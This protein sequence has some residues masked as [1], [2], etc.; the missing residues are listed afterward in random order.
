MR[1]IHRRAVIKLT[2]GA[3]A[4]AA[5]GERR[6]APAAQAPSAELVLIGGTI[7]TMDDSSP[8]A[9]A[10]AVRGGRIQAV[11]SD[12]QIKTYISPSTK[13]I[14]LAGK[15]VTP[16]LID[17]HSHAIG[18]GQMQLKYVQLRPPTVTSFDTLNSELAKAAR[19]KPAG[20]WIVGRGFTE[21]REGRFPRRWELDEAAPGHPVLIIHW[22]GQFG[23]A[24]TLALRKAN[25][26][27]A[28][29]KDPYGG[30]YLRDRLTGLPDGVLIH[31]PAIYS[32][33]QPKLDLN[34]RIDCAAWG[35]EQFARQGVTCIHDNF[36]HPQYAMAYVRLE[37]SGRLPCRVR[38]YPYAKNLEACRLLVER[39]R[40]YRGPQ[41]R[42]QGVKLAVD[43]YALM[44]DVP[45]RHRHMAVPMHPQPL[46]N[47]IVAIIHNADLQADVHAVGDKGV[48]WTLDAFAKAAGSTAECR[49]RRHRIEHFL[50]RNVDSIRRAADLG[51]PVCVQP[52]FLEVRAE[53]IL[54]KLGTGRRQLVDTMVPVQTFDREGVR[55]A[56]GADVP[57]FPSHSPM[58][59]IRSAMARKTA[60]HRQ[61]DATE[62]V[63]FQD[64]LRHHT[65][66][67]A[68]AAFDE[69]ELGSL[70]P[71]KH[72]DF[73][74][75]KND[76]EKVRTGQDAAA[77]EPHAT[78][79]AGMPVYQA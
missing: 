36:C 64:A 34:E 75:W 68:Y 71:G 32:V 28:D 2:V 48:D 23:V 47:Q 69:D 54:Q 52:N 62:A 55:L 7:L 67:S 25:L 38:V 4:G 27:S 60:R 58:D 44:Y 33:Y 40:R 61:L 78:Y 9:G 35:L 57:A 79:L 1:K 3:L 41:V 76:L 43:G 13:T 21:F 56:Y 31:Y 10:L 70:A 45:A 42:L 63:S 29:V 24:N 19:E 6:P 72:A 50:F 66:G 11:G 18:F 37:Q 51:V 46:F 5:M 30:L 77:M 22:G 20:E 49:R 15:H 17:A 73:V 65:T 26:L 12:E 16:G 14:E 59:S 8:R 39:V 74:I 53:D